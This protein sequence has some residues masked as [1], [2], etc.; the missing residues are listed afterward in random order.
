MKSSVK[1]LLVLGGFGLAISA[2]LPSCVATTAGYVGPQASV[3]VGYEVRALPYGYRTEVVS[4]TTYYVHNGSYY[5]PRP[6]GRFVVVTAP[7][8]VYVQ[9]SHPTAVI[10]RLP[11]GYRVVTHRGVRYYQSRNVFY[12]QRGN[13]YV[14]VARPY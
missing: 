6:G 14:I 4:G 5:R 13:G 9:G 1:K 12:Q 10:T 7:R 11:A 3:H 8:R 2:M